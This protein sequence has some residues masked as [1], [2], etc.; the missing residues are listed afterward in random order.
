[1]KFPGRDLDEVPAGFVQAID[2][3]AVV[4]AVAGVGNW[5]GLDRG[6]DR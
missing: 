2:G 5:I 6:G 3:D 4:P 1:V